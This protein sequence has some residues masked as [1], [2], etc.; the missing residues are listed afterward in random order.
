MKRYII[1]MVSV[2]MALTTFAQTMV[3]VQTESEE[4]QYFDANSIEISFWGQ[5][6][7]E[8]QNGDLTITPIEVKG[9]SMSFVMKATLWNKFTRGFYISEIEGAWDV[10]NVTDLGGSTGHASEAKLENDLHCFVINTDFDD[11]DECMVTVTGLMPNTTY[12]IKPFAFVGTYGI[13]GTEKTIITPWTLNALIAQDRFDSWYANSKF[14][15]TQGIYM[16]PTAEAWMSLCNKYKDIFGEEPSEIIKQ[17]LTTEWFRH[18]TPAEADL[19][20]AHSVAYYDNCEDGEVYVLDKVCDDMIPYLLKASAGIDVTKP[21]L[22]TNKNGNPIYTQCTITPVECDASYGIDNNMYIKTEVTNS[23]PTVG[24][25]LPFTL[26]PNRI[27]NVSVTIAPNTED[28]EDTRPNRFRIWVCRNGVTFGQKIAN[29]QTSTEE[30]PDFIYVYGGQKLETFTFQ[31]DTHDESYISDVLKISTEVLSKDKEYYSNVLRLAKI[32]ISS[33]VEDAVPGD[34]DMDGTVDNDDVQTVATAVIL[35]EEVSEEESEEKPSTDFTGDGKTLVDDIVALVN[36]IQ[37]G[38]FKPSSAK[39]RARYAAAAVPEFT[40]EKNLSITAGENTTMSV[41]MSGVADY[42]A[43]SFDIKV[44]EGVRVAIDENGKPIVALGNATATTHNLKAA[45]QEDGKTISVA[46]YA[47]DNACFNK[48]GGSIITVALTTDDDMALDEN[49][50]ISLANCMVT[51][52]NLSSV[53]LDD[54]FIN[55]GNTT[56]VEELKTTDMESVPFTYYTL[57]GIQLSAPQKGFNLIKM[58]D[59]QVK[60]VWVK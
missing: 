18:L 52:P 32:S 27:Y 20:K 49:A 40:T 28:V 31:L 12:Y 15:D 45:M 35:N 46:C 42:T 29:P 4:L 60:K 50:Q 2:W 57:D 33:T 43:A 10:D 51:K 41:D 38:Q 30:E 25:N 6:Q 19:M 54:Y 23:R 53:M 16:L 24:Y 48:T 3:V 1:T 17:A 59:G 7:G 5:P 14:K 56:G 55:T 26:L 37:T 21:N 11:N 39:E 9:N 44:P 22:E 47:D 13:F 58:S 8:E 34:V 36:F